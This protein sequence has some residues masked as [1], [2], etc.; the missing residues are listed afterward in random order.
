MISNLIFTYSRQIFLLP[1][2]AFAFCSLGS[3]ATAPA[4]EEFHNP[5]LTRE[6]YLSL[7]NHPLTH[8]IASWLAECLWRPNSEYEY[9]E[10]FPQWQ[11]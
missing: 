10:V 9:S 2:V 11:Q 1:F 7:H 8:A 3:V 4:R 6:K 5:Y